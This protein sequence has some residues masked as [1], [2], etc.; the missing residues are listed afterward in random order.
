MPL[1]LVDDDEAV[2]DSLSF[3]L[4]QFGYEMTTFV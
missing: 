2:L 3:M 4:R 1:Y